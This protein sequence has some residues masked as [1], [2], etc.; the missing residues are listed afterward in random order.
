MALHAA[1]ATHLKVHVWNETLVKDVHYLIAD[2]GLVEN[3]IF[4]GQ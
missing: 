3:R 4:L 1:A 2:R